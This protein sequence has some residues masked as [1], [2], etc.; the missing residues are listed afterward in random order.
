MVFDEPHEFPD[1]ER[2]AISDALRSSV[3]RM[4]R[5]TTRIVI[6]EEVNQGKYVKVNAFR[7]QCKSGKMPDEDTDDI[8]EAIV[9]V[10][11]N[12]WLHR[13]DEAGE[14]DD[15]ENFKLRFRI[16][17][18]HSEGRKS[19]RT[20]HAFWY[21]ANLDEEDSEETTSLEKEVLQDLLDTLTRQIDS[22]Q[23]YIERLQD[24][25]LA[26][27]DRTGQPLA[28]AGELL[29]M[30]GTMAT[31][32]LQATSNALAMKYSEKK[33]AEEEKAKSER[34]TSV[35]K[36]VAPFVGMGLQQFIQS[37]TGN[38]T[39]PMDFSDQGEE[40]EGPPEPSG[41]PSEEDVEAGIVENELALIAQTFGSS[42]TPEQ[43][44][45]MN[46]KLTKKQIDAVYDI[47]C[48]L[49]D[50]EV[51]EKVKKFQNFFPVDKFP[52]LLGILNEE[53]QQWVIHLVSSVMTRDE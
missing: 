29:K 52:D 43:S 15:S 1:D 41:E 38:V 14:S 2:V 36:T 26:A 32:G 35:M 9:Q 10:A 19:K 18:L 8:C 27:N 42:L 51:V 33:I 49:T 3:Y 28:A 16:A 40:Q 13:L 30:A 34:W 20:T 48:A 47:A 25:L 39:P 37:K 46:S 12:Q 53:Q 21:S 5:S 50:D 31:S 4:L 17:C 11:H 44:R 24:A 6:E 45:A 22:M 7:L 23:S